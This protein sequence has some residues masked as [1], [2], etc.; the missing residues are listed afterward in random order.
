MVWPAPLARAP[1]PNVSFRVDAA[2]AA[3][4]PLSGHENGPE[5][6]RDALKSCRTSYLEVSHDRDN[7]AV[8]RD[9]RTGCPSDVRVYTD[10]G[11]Q[12]KWKYVH[13]VGVSPVS[14]LTNLIRMRLSR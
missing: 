12:G 8:S 1:A 10:E 11:L 5:H 4:A 3:D 9:A 14:I 7:R 6:V 2:T 13:K